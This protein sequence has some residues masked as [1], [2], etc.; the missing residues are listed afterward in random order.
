MYPPTRDQERMWFLRELYPGQPLATVAELLTVAGPLRVQPLRAAVAAL[1]ARHDALRTVFTVDDGRPRAIVLDSVEPPVTFDDDTGGD[2]DDW[3]RSAAREPFDARRGPLL[4]V[5]VRA[6]GPDLHAVLVCGDRLVTDEWSLRTLLTELAQLYTAEVTRSPAALP[7]VTGYSA[8]ARGEHSRL[9]EPTAVAALDARVAALAGVPAGIELPADRLRPPRLSFAGDRLERRLPAALAARVT[10]LAAS[11]S[12]EPAHVML[13]ALVALVGRY[14][15][16]TDV[17]VGMAGPDYA[18]PGMPAAVVGPSGL[19][20][21]RADLA[22]DPGLTGVLDQVAAGLADPAHRYAPFGLLAER[23]ATRRDMSRRPLCQVAFAAVPAVEITLPDASVTVR[24]VNTGTSLYDLCLSVVTGDGEPILGV[25]YDTELFARTSAER[26]AASYVTLLAAAV[27]APDEP[28]GNLPLLDGAEVERLLAESAG[29]EVPIPHP[30]LVHEQITAQAAAR[31]DAL[32]LVAGTERVTF[33]ELNRRANSVANHLRTAGVRPQTPVAVCLPRS[34]DMVVAVLGVLK[35]G[36]AAVL[37]DPAQPARRLEGMLED[38]RAPVLLTSATLVPAMPN[39]YGGAV[40][41]MDRDWHLIARAGDAEPPNWSHPAALCQIAYTSGSTGEPRGVAFQHDPVRNVAWA[42]QRTY[43]LTDQDHGSWISAPGFGISFVNELWPF[44]TIGA[45]VH[46]ADEETVSSPFRLRDWL[47]EQGVTVSLL[48]KALAERV[49]AADWPADPA[50]RVLMVSGERSGWLPANVPFEVVTIYGS[51]ETTN[52][53]TCLNEAAGWRYTPRSVPPERRLSATAPAGRPVPNSRVYLLD[54]RLQLVPDGVAGQVYVGGSLVQGGYL[55]RPADTAAKWRPDPYSPRPGSRMVATGDLARRLPDGCIEILGRADEQISLNGY[56]VEPGEIA[57]RLLAH[58][59]VRQSAVLVIEPEPGE[60]RIAAYVVPEPNRLPASADLREMLRA[61]LPAYMVPA[62]FVMIESLPMLPNGKVDRRALPL[63]GATRAGGDEY[64]AP[65]NDAQR[66]L[67]DIW[68]AVLHRE[69]VGI[70]ENYFELGGDSLTGIELVAAAGD[71]FG[72]TLPLRVLFEAPTVEQMTAVLARLASPAADRGEDP[73]EA[74]IPLS[75][76]RRCDPFPLT[77]IQHAY[78]IGRTGGLELG[79]VGCHGYQEWDVERLDVER[80]EKAIDRL[81]HRHDMLRAIVTGDGRQR[82]LASVPPYQ[83]AVADLRGLTPQARETRLAELREQ[84]SHAVLPANRWPLFQVRATLLDEVSARIHLSFD[85]LIF[86]ARSARVF[87]QELAQFYRDPDL[88]LPDLELSFRDYAVAEL[89]AARESAAYLTS[90][91]YWRARL[92]ELPPAPDLPYLR[93]L[94]AVC[95][96]RFVRHTGRLAPEVW[97][98]LRQAASRAGITP[99]ALLLAAY[100]EVLATWSASPRFTVNLTLFH[101]PPLHPQLNDILG[102]FTSGLLL[103]VDGAGGSFADRVRRVQEQLWR[104][105]E[106]RQVSSVTVMRELTRRQGGAGPRA[107]MPVVF[108]SLVG[109]PRMEWGNLGRYVYGVT[110]TPQVALD[111]QVMEVDGGL[112]Y[113]WDAIAELFPHGLVGEMADASG[114]LLHDLAADAGTWQQGR[115]VGPPPAQ[116]EARR[117]VN[118]TRSPLP[119]GPLHGPILRQFAERSDAQ[120]VVDGATTLT[121]GDLDRVSAAVAARLAASGTAGP[122]R[123]VGVLMHKGWEQVAAV[124]GILRAGGAYLP[125]D[126]HLPP[127]RITYLVDNGQVGSLLLQPDTADMAPA[128]VDTIVVELGMPAPHPAQAGNAAAGPDSLAYVIYTSGSTG[129]PKGVMIEHRP[130]LNT[131]ADI[132]RRFGLGPGDSVL[133]VSSLSFDLSVWDIFGVL[134][135]GG[136]LVLPPA[137]SNPEPAAW[138]ELLAQHRVTVWNSAPALLQILIE[139]LAGQG[140]RLPDSL[141]TIM[142]SGDWIAPGLYDQLRSLASRARLISL[143]G[144]TEAAIWSIWHEVGPP[145]PEWASVPYGRPLANQRW[146]VLDEE[147]NPRPDWVTGGLYIA[148]AGLARGYWRDEAKTAARFVS[149]QRTGERLYRTGDLGRYR[150]GEVLEILGREDFQVKILGQRVELGEIDAALQSHPQVAACCAVAVGER[151]ALRLVAHVVAEPGVEPSTAD[152]RRHL[153]GKLP[154]ELVP[155]RYVFHAALPLTPNGKVDRSALVAMG[156]PAIG[157]PG[158][159]AGGGPPV[160][161]TEERLLP[162]VAEVLGA[163]RLGPE[164]N[165]FAVGGDSL[166]AITVINEA[167]AAGLPIPVAV[168]FRHPTV[169]ELAAYLDAAG[170]GEPSGFTVLDLR[171][172]SR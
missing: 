141:R 60:R 48:A 36:G 72:V 94:S 86:D 70:K 2:V 137:S 71:A 74:P 144:A 116:L 85:L 30:G 100:A 118:A 148:G 47:V 162:I 49:C 50:L 157:G 93:G 41:C 139:Y 59:S 146:H 82:V 154:A 61:E 124:L 92:D 45:A 75:P 131:V 46:I 98:E 37:L 13:A 1:A 17:V 15:G 57:T 83:M 62:M 39:G 27:D 99:S 112:D 24:T 22:G 52:A 79:D 3:A 87:T 119:D 77:D 56:R 80:L 168:F 7:A 69:R 164:D 149:D 88:T 42:T 89:G 53:T 20:V 110:Q 111:H 40:Y 105:L 145:S 97:R 130:A 155:A 172:D 136:R 135:A 123:L 117:A 96:P 35:A 115:P 54:D 44:L 171:E 158:E 10:E 8:V 11:R 38:S 9:A 34:A 78:W 108:S 33:G 6:V 109:V 103:A 29:E 18:G 104:D 81:V 153:S 147:L 170:P 32:A 25:D 150:P 73:A 152:L 133:G 151:A 113:A 26:F 125:I 134:G 63:P 126:P 5:R 55:H 120:A 19:R 65:E 43:S 132:N 101:R 161:P 16:V 84:L 23:L 121:F 14:A 102:D 90:L 140:A 128:G 106:H 122:E 165:F 51:T 67:A 76:A 127:E 142:L 21:L 138:A 95:D 12:A 91:E 166:R 159:T 58:P 4:R 114:R 143:G 156:E 160:G 31:P 167:A 68:S 64:A 66:T 169:R 163:Q 107:V 28:V 129:E